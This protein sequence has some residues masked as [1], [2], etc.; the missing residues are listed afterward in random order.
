MVNYNKYGVSDLFLEQFAYPELKPLEQDWRW[1]HKYCYDILKAK[2]PSCKKMQWAALRHF[3]DMQNDE[4][5]FDEEAAK[6]I[7]LWFKFCPIVKGSKS[8]TAMILEP[9]Q[10]Y[11]SV[12]LMAWKWSEDLYETDEDTG[13]EMQVRHAHKRRF[14][15]VYAQVSRKYGK[16][17]W[18][19]GIKLYLMYK[20]EYGP[21]VFSLATKKDQAK[22][23]WNVAKKMIKLSP[24][25]AAIFEPRANDILYPSKDGEFKALAS[26]S[27]SLDGLDPMAA[28]LDECHAIKDRNLYGVLISAFGSN[29]G[30][31]FLFSV[32]TTAGFILNGLCTDLYK[33]GASVL[34]PDTETKQDNYFY[35]IFEIDKGDDWTDQKAWF[36]ANPGLIYG[37]PSI[38]YMRDRLQEATMSVEEKGNFLTKHCNLFVSGSDK[39][40][41]MDEVRANYR[42]KLTIEQIGDQDCALGIDAAQF[43]DITSFS[44]VIPT[45]DGGVD[46]YIRNLLP[47]SAFNNAGDYLREIYRKAIDN[48]DLELVQTAS[49]RNE[50][51]EEMVRWFY[52]RFPGLTTTYYDP[53][54]MRIPCENLEDEGYD[55]VA[56][57]QSVGNL[58]EAQ[59]RTEALIKEELLRYNNVLFEYACECAMMTLT[60]KDNADVWRENPKVDK[61]DPLK[62]TIFALAGVTLFKQDY[63]PYDHRGL[64]TL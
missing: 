9:S 14:N 38:K 28:C 30:G 61:I 63:N 41:D 24:R 52:N 45:Q 42:P 49:I 64:M 6:S 50:Q 43:H 57:S 3:Q 40:L 51:I 54:K 12:S 20:Y 60:R 4:F 27:N 11:L 5:Y 25:L 17:S 8:G 56:V 7:V 46:T 1:C 10:I 59:K 15:Q 39:W 35:A 16:T 55:M 44:L 21:R 19:A 36:K 22:E 53:Y 23:V 31:E 33:N 58:S 2:I 48:G 34:N 62:A 29:E 32:I 13:I 18:I 47:Q 26:D 37:R